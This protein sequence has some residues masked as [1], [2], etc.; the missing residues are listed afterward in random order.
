MDRNA[1]A[2]RD[3]GGYYTVRFWGSLI[4]STES[5][6]SRV[7]KADQLMM[8]QNVANN[9]AVADLVLDTQSGAHA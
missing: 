1:P 6:S 8:A 3:E 4:L 5:I 9:L 2:I 7:A